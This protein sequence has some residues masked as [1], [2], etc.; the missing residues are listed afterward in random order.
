[1][2]KHDKEMFRFVLLLTKFGNICMLRNV[3]WK[4]IK[5]QKKGECVGVGV[6]AMEGVGMEPTFL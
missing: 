2:F 1:M 4:H 3:D 6:G 5:W